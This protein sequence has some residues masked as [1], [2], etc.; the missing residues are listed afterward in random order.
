M[1]DWKENIS[2]IR[3]LLKEEG[4]QIAITENL[5]WDGFPLQIES[6]NEKEISY[7][8]AGKKSKL[9]LVLINSEII[10]LIVKEIKNNKFL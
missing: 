2:Y 10:D 1:T 6:V 5:E 7:I 4:G 8:F 3:N 9:S